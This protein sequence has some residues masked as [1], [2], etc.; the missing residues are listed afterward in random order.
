[1]KRKETPAD[2]ESALKNCF[3][4][5]EHLREYGGS[6]PVIR[7]RGKHESCAQSYHVLQGKN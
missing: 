7:G 6:D 4:R 2:Y 1:M 5:W 3:D